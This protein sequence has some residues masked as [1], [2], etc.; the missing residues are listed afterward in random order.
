MATK[1]CPICKGKVALTRTSC[2]HCGY[3]FGERTCPACGASL[4]NNEAVCSECGFEF[5][6]DN[7]NKIVDIKCPSCG[8]NKLH[9]IDDDD[10]KCLSCES[11][12]KV[13]DTRPIIKNT[14]INTNENVK[15]S[16]IS[17]SMSGSTTDKNSLT[18]KDVRGTYYPDGTF[19]PSSSYSKND[20]EKKT[21]SSS[22]FSYADYTD[23]TKTTHPALKKLYDR[24][25]KKTDFFHKWVG[26]HHVGFFIG[27]IILYGV[28]CAKKKDDVI[29]NQFSNIIWCLLIVFVSAHVLY[30]LRWK[31]VDIMIENIDSIRYDDDDQKAKS[32]IRKAFFIN[33][34]ILLFIFAAA[35]V[36]FILV[37]N[38]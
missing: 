6:N 37:Y 20:D 3:K 28:L 7:T 22:S 18:S 27:T 19:Y 17:R 14:I 2:P 23:P 11:F 34:P 9:R 38:M 36:G 13:S 15:T 8:S 16:S 33:Y 30:F 24:L 21:N 25:C 10:Y 29:N 26:P 35:V 4:K 1:N 32:K 12:F 31:I 5:K